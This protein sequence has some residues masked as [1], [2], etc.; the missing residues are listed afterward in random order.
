MRRSE[1]E[2]DARVG[3]VSLSELATRSAAPGL[4]IVCYHGV[5]SEGSQ[6]ND[7]LHIPVSEFTEQVELLAQ[8]FNVVSIDDGMRMLSAGR[9]AG[10]TACITFDDGYRNNAAVAYP[11]LKRLG[12]KATIY[13][14]TELVGTPRILWTTELS[15]ALQNGS[16]DSIDLTRWGGPRLQHSPAISRRALAKRVVEFLKLQ[17]PAIRREALAE[18]DLSLTSQSADF[19]EYS[20]MDWNDVRELA[21]SGLVSFGGHTKTH[22]IVSRLDDGELRDQLEGSVRTISREL[23][24]HQG[25]S[26][27]QTFAYPNGRQVDFDSRAADV[28][29]E[30]GVEAAVTTISGVNR[31]QADPFRLRRLVVGPQLPLARFAWLATGL[32]PQL[33]RMFSAISS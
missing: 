17:P 16:C 32:N 33:A 3:A 7:W 6:V 25:D 11:I 5:A 21:D 14:A 30:L 20:L 23:Q 31:G 27:S 10:P 15:L 1:I 13:L 19:A 12:L 9:L 24:R 29:R 2:R 26:I 8:R 4:L 22:E 28:L 18:V